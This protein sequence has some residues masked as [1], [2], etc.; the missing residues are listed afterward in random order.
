MVTRMKSH[1]N[2]TRVT[3][4]EL[5]ADLAREGISGRTLAARLDMQPTYV[6]RRLAGEVPCTPEDFVA[7]A[8]VLGTRAGKYLDTA[9]RVSAPQQVPVTA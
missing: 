5:R 4:A 6:A 3:A 2:A 8:S 9:Q 1:T 7:F